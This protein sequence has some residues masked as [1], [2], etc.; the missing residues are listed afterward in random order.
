MPIGMP[1]WPESAFCTASMAR[2]RM[3][4]ATRVRSLEATVMAVEV[5]T[6][7]VAMRAKEP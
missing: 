6:L 7:A 4:L 5:A 2:P 1:G 3:V